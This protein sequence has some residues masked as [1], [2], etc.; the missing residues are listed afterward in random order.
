MWERQQAPDAVREVQ[1]RK[2]ARLAAPADQWKTLEEE[3]AL[4][5]QRA[6]ALQ[7][8]SHPRADGVPD[9]QL[10]PELPPPAPIGCVVTMLSAPEFLALHGSQQLM[11]TIQ[12]WLSILDQHAEG[13]KSLLLLVHGL[14]MQVQM[15]SNQS[16]Q[17]RRADSQAGAA[18]ADAA[19]SSTPRPAVKPLKKLGDVDALLAQL[20]FLTKG[21]VKLKM[22]SAR[23]KANELESLLECAS[24]LLAL[25]V[26]CALSSMISTSAWIGWCS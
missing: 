7:N 10:V 22:V 26:S 3:A 16:M 8:Q 14:Y 23:M 9:R 13:G 19:A 21:R 15:D 4:N 5:A 11:P 18:S 24:P 1:A 17:Q 2:R 6:A 20:W 12:R 25:F